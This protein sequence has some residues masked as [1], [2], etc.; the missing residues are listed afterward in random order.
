MQGDSRKTCRGGTRSSRTRYNL[1][2]EEEKNNN[3]RV[4]KSTL[5]GEGP[6]DNRP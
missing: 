1:Q 5:D 3:V 2:E 6:V 4:T